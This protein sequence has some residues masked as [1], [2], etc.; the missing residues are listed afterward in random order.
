MIA[1]KIL[2]HDKT[3]FIHVL[4]SPDNYGYI[5]AML[6]V[7]FSAVRPQLMSNHNTRAV[8]FT[9]SLVDKQIITPD[10]IINLLMGLDIND[11]TKMVTMKYTD[12]IEVV[13][14][15]AASLKSQDSHTYNIFEKINIIE[16]VVPQTKIV[17]SFF[18]SKFSIPL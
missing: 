13:L 1:Y 11:S 5:C 2:K 14:K 18:S 15:Y 6:A 10:D 9:H 12:T 7:T 4:D 8:P 3:E 17:D 16:S